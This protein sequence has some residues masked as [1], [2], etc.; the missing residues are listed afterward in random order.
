MTRYDH[1]IA[2]DGGGSSTR[3]RL[4]GADGVLLSSASAG[5]SALGLGAAAAW[6][7]IEAAV[8]AAFAA[9]GLGEPDLRRVAAGIGLAGTE[10]GD[11]VAAFRAAAAG[12]GALA[13]ASDA[14]TALLGAHAGAPGAVVAV[15]TG[16]VGRALYANGRCASVG[17]WGFPAGDEGG[18]A[19]LGMRAAS[20]A[21]Q[22]LDGRV[23]GGALAAAV[24]AWAGGSAA[25]LLDWCVAAGPSAFAQL[26]PLIF[27]AEASDPVAAELLSQ[28]VQAVVQMAE[29]LDPKGA[30]PLVLSGSIAQ[31]LQPRLPAALLARCVAPAGDACDGALRLIQ[32]VLARGETR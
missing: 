18:G 17:G 6:R 16:S 21:Q 25:A 31:R 8:G 14:H 20:H 23:R 13:L 24:L 32:S 4:F 12:L 26:A 19:W 5:P 29:A 22:A 7:Q 2:V 30:L 3:L 11:A 10:R 15:G 9:A 27:D 28:A 1:S